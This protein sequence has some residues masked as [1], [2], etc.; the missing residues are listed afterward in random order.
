MKKKKP[1]VLLTVTTILMVLS[2]SAAN[3]VP[4]SGEYFDWIVYTEGKEVW[5]VSY[6]ILKTS[7]FLHSEGETY[8]SQFKPDISGS[9]WFELS[10]Y[11][12]S[13]DAYAYLEYYNNGW[14]TYMALSAFTD[15]EGY[16]QPS[17]APRVL[18]FQSIMREPNN[19]P[20]ITKKTTLSLSP[21][22]YYRIR[23]KATHRGE[24]TYVDVDS[25]VYRKWEWGYLYGQ[26]SGS[27]Y[28]SSA[29]W[30]NVDSYNAPLT[31][32]HGGTVRDIEAWVL[33]DNNNV[34]ARVSDSQATSG[35]VQARVEYEISISSVYPNPAYRGT[36][37][38]VKYTLNA[39]GYVKADVF[40]LWGQLVHTKYYG[41]V[42][43]CTNREVV[44]WDG[45]G[46][47]AGIYTVRFKVWN[48]EQHAYSNTK[49][50][51]VL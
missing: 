40:N 10:V 26:D 50:F 51:T 48:S 17:V 6:D 46:V 11:S 4:T 34:E 20:P 41:W 49:S 36:N 14:R 22:K 15:D 23:L 13:T 38:K 7:T 35:Y 1:F 27:A 16:P 18:G 33:W 47:A 42:T 3:S 39:D 44:F 43:A 12:Y 37:R 29:Y 19:P 31:P 8:S 25:R 32:Q 2:L 45:S 24:G 30:V 9:F 28:C 5:S 21:D